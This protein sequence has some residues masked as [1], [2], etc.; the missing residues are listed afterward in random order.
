M[1]EWITPMADDDKSTPSSIPAMFQDWIDQLSAAAGYA[2]GSR[3][4][5]PASAATPMLPGALSAAQMASITDSIAAQRRSIAALQT[6]LSAFDEQLAAL[7]KLLGPLAQ[8]SKS[9]ADLEQGV[10]NMGSKP[11]TDG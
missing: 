2:G 10:M 1:S 3:S 9:W 11:K 5:R 7:E 8:W 4:S 6:Q